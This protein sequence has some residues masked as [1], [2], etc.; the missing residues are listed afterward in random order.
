MLGR[1]TAATTTSISVFED[2]YFAFAPF[3][4]PADIFL[5]S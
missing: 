5:M 1:T 2:G 3:E 4:Q